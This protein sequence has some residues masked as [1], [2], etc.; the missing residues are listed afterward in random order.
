MLLPAAHTSP[1]RSWRNADIT[2]LGLHG[3]RRQ[4][5][6]HAH[7]DDDELRAG[8]RRN[9]GLI[10]CTVKGF[11]FSTSSTPALEPTQP[12]IQWVPGIFS[13]G[14]SGRSV[15]L[16][17]H[18]HLVPRLRMAELYINS[19]VRLHCLVRAYA[20]AGTTLIPSCL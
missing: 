8:R 3:D 20:N 18:L 12:L 4:S 15:K 11:S 5:F 19:S 2:E 6:G 17:T 9:Q 14:Y 7:K 1:L 13:R 16:T 10:P